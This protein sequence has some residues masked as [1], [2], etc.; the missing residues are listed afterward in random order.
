MAR[1]LVRPLGG[2]AKSLLLQQQPYPV[3]FNLS[4][5]YISEMRREAFE[6]NILRL[7]RYEIRYEL[8]RSPPSQP[9]GEFDS[10]IIDE[11]PGEQWIKL[12][13]KFEENEEI[14]VEVTMFDASVPVNKGNDASVAD[15]VQL[16]ITM[17]VNVFKG[18]GNDVL[19]F[20]CS[21]WPNSIEIRK[22]YMRGQ[23]G[24]VDQP[25][26]GPPFKEL[27]DELQDSLYDFLETRG[28]NDE[29]CVFLHRYMK[30]KDKLE[31]IRW[32]EKA[33]SFMERK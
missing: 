33:K 20:V 26:V 22:V 18:E 9:I 21:A 24:V 8:E 25:Y 16:H 1:R 10:F 15:D 13:K 12:N 23:N 14:K 19:E 3:I 7:L 30:N 31:F 11:R 29:F 2:I 4:R 28:I 5:N 17:I 32:M 27:D 6:G